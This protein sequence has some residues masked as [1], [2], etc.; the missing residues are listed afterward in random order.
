MVLAGE[1]L[2]MKHDWVVRVTRSISRGLGFSDYR[3]YLGVGQA[4]SVRV[5]MGRDER[6]PDENQHDHSVQWTSTTKPT[7]FAPFV[8][9]DAFS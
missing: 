4:F 3:M 2:R 9:S 1:I 8:S 5:G 6:V 7:S